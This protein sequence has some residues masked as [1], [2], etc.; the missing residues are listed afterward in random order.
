M[1]K[2]LALV[3][4]LGALIGAGGGTHAA[5]LHRSAPRLPRVHIALGNPG[6]ANR[7]TLAGVA[8]AAGDHLQR[9]FDLRSASKAPIARI[10]LSTTA[11]RSSL[12]DRNRVSG[13]QLRLDRCSRAWRA[14]RARTYG[15]SG[16][17]FQVLGWRPVLGSAVRLRNLGDLTKARTAHLLMTLALPQTGQGAE[18]SAKVTVYYTE[19]AGKKVAHFFQKR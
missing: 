2:I 3:A 10:A 12:L 1:L 13:L 11:T 4:S 18:K 9:P 14:T 17:Q 7:L 19:E 5:S 16:T 6:P 15:C 8:L